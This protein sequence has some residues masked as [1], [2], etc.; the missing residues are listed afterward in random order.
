MKI[1]F[2]GL[3]LM[4]SRMANNL[5]Q[6]GNSL[7]VFNRTKEKAKTLV[8]GGAVLCSSIADAAAQS[9]IMITMLSEP[10]VVKEA[11][12]GEKGFLNN[13]KKD[14]VWIDCSTVNPEFSRQM[15]EEAKQ[16]GI[17]FLDAPVAGTITPA[18]K[19]ELTFFIGGEKD[20]VDFC[21]PV[22]E[23]MGKKII[24]IGENGKGTSVKIVINLLL[25][26]AI[27]GFSEGLLLG[28]SLGVPKEKLLELLLG[29]PAAAPFLSAKK[30]KFL[31]NNFDTEFPLQWMLKDLRL[32]LTEA[33]ANNIAL[34]LTA[35]AEEIFKFANEAGLG[36]ED[37]SAVYKFLNG[38]SG[39][40]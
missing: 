8:D 38:G 23:A 4:G 5:L 26:Q 32:A 17:R 15:A 7:F 11:A 37:F 18:E 22:F 36:E 6:K 14:S 24:H 25:G 1:G 9:D 3:G 12:L 40:I 21:M 28:E 35:G 39:S 10:G 34:S 27:A 20:D 29:G 19:G 31:L 30:D 33:K 13:L 16:R 2:I